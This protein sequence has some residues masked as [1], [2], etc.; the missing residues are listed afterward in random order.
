MLNNKRLNLVK[1]N[2]TDYLKPKDLSSFVGKCFARTSGTTGMIEYIIKVTNVTNTR[3]EIIIVYNNFMISGDYRLQL[4][5]DAIIWLTIEEFKEF[6][7]DS[8][9]KELN[10]NDIKNVQ[11]KID[12]LT[13][14]RDYLKKLL[15]NES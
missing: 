2:I 3:F 9:L 8:D 7:E 13:E 14:F 4:E 1:E 12:E 10:I 15:N 6:V 11:H 5:E